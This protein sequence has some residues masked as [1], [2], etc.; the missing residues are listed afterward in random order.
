M[1]CLLK[2][3]IRL[4]GGRLVLDGIKGRVGLLPSAKAMAK[5]DVDQIGPDRRDT[6]FAK[7]VVP[8]AV[9]ALDV[10]LRFGAEV[11]YKTV[12]AEFADTAT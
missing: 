2:A 7:V 12:H 5:R 10:Q 1:T 9:G 4:V 11:Q 6:L 3:Y 8:I